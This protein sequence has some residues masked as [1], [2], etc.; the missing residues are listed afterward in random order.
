MKREQVDDPRGFVAL[1]KH[2]GVKEK[3]LD[4][5]VVASEQDAA[6]AAVLTRSRFCGAPIPIA[7]SSIADGRL[8]A[9]T[10]V[11]GNANVATGPQ[12]ERDAQEV[13]EL[14]AGELSIEPSRILP[15]ATGVIGR[16]LPM[17]TIRDG[18]HGIG[19]SLGEGQLEAAAEAIMTTDSHV[20]VASVTLGDV[21]LTGMA[22]GAGMMAPDMATLLSFFFTDADIPQPELDRL[23]RRVV[24]RTYNRLSV[25]TDTSTS[26]TVALMANGLAGPVDLDDFGSALEEMALTFTRE[27]A[28]DGEGA[29][30]LLLVTVRQASDEQQAERVGKTVVNSPLVKTA[31]FGGDPNWGRVAMAIGKCFEDPILPDEVQIAFGGATVYDGGEIA[32]ESRL[33]ELEGYL[34]GEEVQIDIALGLGDTE[35]T[36]YGCDL[37]YDYVR[38]NG[39]YTS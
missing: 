9:I 36:V 1:A 32:N 11:A 18:V 8:R 26:D 30:K 21:T 15:A 31:A 10:A 28:R 7:R 20:K 38:L 17:Q 39:E 6:A 4:F 5:M 25:D 35:A 2:V 23:L 37:S 14:V 22:K 24:G 13:V 16:R 34:E 27:I 3:N 19:G 33:K 12:G 29:T